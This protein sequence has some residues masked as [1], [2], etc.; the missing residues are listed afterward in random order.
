PFLVPGATDPPTLSATL[1][2]GPDVVQVAAH[3]AQGQRVDALL[4]IG[5]ASPD[6]LDLVLQAATSDLRWTVDLPPDTAVPAGASLEVPVVVH[7][8]S[9][10]WRD[11]P[12]RVTI[13]A[14]SR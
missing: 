14:R 13:A 5:N 6:D 1:A 2:L 9:D 7:V 12:V 11:I 4:T 3:V 8:P 10:A